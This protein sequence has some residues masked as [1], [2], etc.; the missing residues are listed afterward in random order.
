[1]HVDLA[2]GFELHVTRQPFTAGTALD[3]TAMLIVV[4]E[5]LIAI[6]GV[7]S[8]DVWLGRQESCNLIEHCWWVA[9]MR[10]KALRFCGLPA[11]KGS[12]LKA[13]YAGK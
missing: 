11:V 3:Y 1:M 12:E 8:F 9:K 13:H 5:S 6:E 10:H 7:G 4:D 2:P